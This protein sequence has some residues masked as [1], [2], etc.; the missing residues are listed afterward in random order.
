MGIC[1]ITF[2]LQYSVLVI[3]YLM[4]Q[5]YIL[6]KLKKRS[7]FSTQSLCKTVYSGEVFK[8]NK[9]EGKKSFLST[10]SLYQTDSMIFTLSDAGSSLKQL[11][12]K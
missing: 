7:I 2:Q 12:L 3:Y 8:K 10:Q 9:K 11:K 6:E 1:V 4:I 5:M